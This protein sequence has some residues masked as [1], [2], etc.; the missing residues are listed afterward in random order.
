MHLRNDNLRALTLALTV[1]FA[2]AEAH[3]QVDV[4]AW[5]QVQ[6]EVLALDAQGIRLEGLTKD[7]LVV[8]EGKKAHAIVALKPA[9]EPQSICLLI[10]A[11]GSM[12]TRLDVVL[13]KARRF[14]KS[15]PPD[16][17]ICVADFSGKLFVRHS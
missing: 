14:A 4:S 3:G 10:D 1:V 11:S 7:E 5:P 16:D 15:L 13:T 17:E 6:M 8:K 2:T 9:S 12:Y